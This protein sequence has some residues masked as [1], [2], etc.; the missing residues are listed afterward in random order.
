MRGIDVERQ[1]LEP[2]QELLTV[3]VGPHHPATHGVLR[4]V[5]DLEGEV[6]RDLRPLMGYVHTGIEKSCEDKSYWKV[7]PFVERMDY[8]AYFF[9]ME[10]FCGAVERLLELEIPP[11]AKY[12]RVIH[13]ELNRIHSHLVGLG[14]T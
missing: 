10:A 8:L 1:E 7:I 5:V 3:N 13:M 4:L 6:V 2:E 9:N 11:R 12:L 14:T